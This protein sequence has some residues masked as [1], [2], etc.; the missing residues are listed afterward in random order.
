MKMPQILLEQSLQRG[1][2]LHSTMFE[3]INHGKF[4]VIIGISDS[5]VAGFFFINSHIHPS[6]FTNQLQ[7]DMQYLLKKE[8]YSFLHYDSFLCATHIIQKPLQKIKES[9]SKGETTIIAQLKEKHIEE[10]L[11]MVRN[12]KLF[13][14]I[15]KETFFT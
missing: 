7:L 3:Y 10:V 2:I 8:D 4:F 5:L 9:L 14:K 6:I 11:E 15:E 1:A 12:S 13:S